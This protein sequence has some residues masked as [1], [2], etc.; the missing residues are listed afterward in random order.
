MLDSPMQA[1][2]SGALSIGVLVLFILAFA[3]PMLRRMLV[4]LLPCGLLRQYCLLTV[5][6]QSQDLK[7]EE[8]LCDLLDH[9][10]SV[11][12]AGFGA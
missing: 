11:P 3:E 2:A 9:H 4:I 10:A 6:T 1:F 7:D 5:P 8:V 12:D